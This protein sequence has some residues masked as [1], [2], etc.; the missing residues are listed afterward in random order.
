MVPIK[1]IKTMIYSFD[2][3]KS[4]R[5]DAVLYLIGPCDE[6]PDYYL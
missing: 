3:V 5:P 4:S 1:D 2:L 6:D